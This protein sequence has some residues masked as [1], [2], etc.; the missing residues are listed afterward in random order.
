MV[1]SGD[2]LVRDGP[3]GSSL[4]ASD[5]ECPDPYTVHVDGMSADV[6]G[7]NV[8]LEGHPEKK[9]VTDVPPDGSTK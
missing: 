7:D 1:T 9:L 8:P 3:Y 6:W 4:G 2:S 5:G